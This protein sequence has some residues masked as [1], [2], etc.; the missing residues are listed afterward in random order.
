MSWIAL[1]MPTL[2]YAYIC[3][4]AGLIQK[5]TPSTNW[6]FSWY[7]GDL[8]RWLWASQVL[9]EA[10]ASPGEKPL[11]TNSIKITAALLGH[12]LLGHSIEG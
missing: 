4:I 9:Q 12:P 6:G 8:R 5:G 3:S 11:S 2:Q 1:T 7:Q 10:S